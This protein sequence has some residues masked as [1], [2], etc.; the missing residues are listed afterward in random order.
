MPSSAADLIEAQAALLME[1]ADL[2]VGFVVDHCGLLH[3]GAEDFADGAH[4]A[5]AGLGSLAGGGARLWA[6][7][8]KPDRTGCR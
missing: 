1:E 3:H 2:A 6:P 5:D 4:L 8:S 7:G